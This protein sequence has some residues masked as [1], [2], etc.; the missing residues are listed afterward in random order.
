MGLGQI[1]N[2]KLNMIQL[3]VLEK[4]REG[5]TLHEISMQIGLNEITVR[6]IIRSAVIKLDARS[7]HHAIAILQAEGVD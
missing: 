4:L 6:E 5:N 2:S 7:T 3:V 1:R